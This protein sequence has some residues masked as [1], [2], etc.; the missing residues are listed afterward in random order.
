MLILKTYSVL[1]APFGLY[2]GVLK[3][4]CKTNVLIGWVSRD[5]KRKE[6]AIR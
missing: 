5:V 4:S 2:S 6:L 3:I 1:D